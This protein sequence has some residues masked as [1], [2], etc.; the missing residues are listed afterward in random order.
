MQLPCLPPS[1]LRLRYQVFTLD[2]TRS[3]APHGND[4]TVAPA[5][6]DEGCQQSHGLSPFC[7]TWGC[8]LNSERSPSR[9]WIRRWSSDRGPPHV[10]RYARA[11]PTQLTI[12]ALNTVFDL[13]FHGQTP[14]SFVDAVTHAWSRCLTAGEA[15][16][17][18]AAAQPA[19]PLVVTTPT[20]DS[21]EA[22]RA[23]LQRLSQ[24][25]TRHL[26]AAQT[27]RLLMFHAGAV[28][29]PHT[30]HSIA[31]VASSGTGKTTLSRLLGLTHGYLTDETVG[32]DPATGRI[33]PY[34]KPLSIAPGQHRRKVETSPDEL[35]LL[36]AHPT[37]KLARL[38]VLNRSATHPREPLAEAL[39]LLDA[40]SAL[41]PQTSALNR[42]PRPL[43]TVADL[44]H[45]TGPL[46]HITYREARDLGPT[47]AALLE[48][49]P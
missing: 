2:Q 4:S 28:S 41:V 13:T 38:V 29:H 33:H 21:P 22:T 44:L 20:D 49:T 6:A 37:P 26:I 36:P 16:I 5:I 23:A 34:P 8:E 10:P 31:Y 7:G 45:A 42:L 24:E 1:T 47:L 15:S 14:R 39:P 35:G 9:Q 11:V 46:L 48:E 30:G 17:A 3:V 19:E 43:R 18:V 32:I 40:V 25:V 27:G 12:T